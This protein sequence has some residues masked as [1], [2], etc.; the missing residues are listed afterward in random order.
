MEVCVITGGGSGMGLE[1]AKHM[2]RHKIIV[3]AGRTETKLERGAQQ[4]REHG[5]TA[6][7]KSCDVSDK[8]N[9][10]RSFYDLFQ[11]CLVKK[12]RISAGSS[13]V[14]ACSFSPYTRHGY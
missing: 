7:I 9:V 3:L 10:M 5:F 14:L 6:Y 2:D 11:P 8:Q 12:L 13:Q 1:A 4:L